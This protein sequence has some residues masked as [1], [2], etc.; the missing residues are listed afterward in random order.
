MSLQKLITNISQAETI[1]TKELSSNTKD[2][3]NKIRRDSKMTN[4]T[5]LSPLTVLFFLFYL[6]FFVLHGRHRF[7]KV[8][9]TKKK[10]KERYIK[11][12]IDAMKWSHLKAQY[13][14]KWKRKHVANY[15]KMSA[16]RFSRSYQEAYLLKINQLF[17]SY[18]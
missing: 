4:L 14:M 12:E 5:E 18:W 1:N 10:K 11:W 3:G 17:L 13:L 7:C 9:I 15:Q 2:T 6:H 8:Q 16:N